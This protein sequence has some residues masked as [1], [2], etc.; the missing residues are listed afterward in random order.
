VSDEYSLYGVEKVNVG[1][2]L[3]KCVRGVGCDPDL[4][5]DVLVMD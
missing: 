4:F 5:T 2:A 3:R 1:Q